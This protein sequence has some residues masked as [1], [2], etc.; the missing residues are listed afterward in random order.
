MNP[1]LLLAVV[2]CLLAANA[3]AQQP[4]SR[5]KSFKPSP[6]AQV[7]G[8]HREAAPQD[9][10]SNGQGGASFVGPNDNCAAATAISGNGPFAFDTVGA[11]TDGPA[12]CTGFS[13]DVWFNWTASVSATFRVEL[14]GGATF[15]TELAVYDG[16]AC[17]G[18]LIG[19]NDD[20]CGLQSRMTFNAING[21][22][23]KIQIGGY[24]G[25]NGT[26]SFTITQPPPPP[27]P[28]PDLCSA[29]G[30]ISGTGPFNFNNL[31][32]TTGTQGQNNPSCNLSGETGI[33]NDVWFRWTAAQN[34]SATLTLCGTT[35]GVDTKVAIYANVSGCPVALA[36]AC[37][38]DACALES[39]ITWCVT[40]GV[41]Y[42][43]QLG[44][45]PTASPGT[46]TF[47]I[48]TNPQ[49]SGNDECGGAL[50]LAPTGPYSFNTT[51]ATTS[52]AGQSNSACS[53]YNQMGIHNDL[54]FTWTAT[55]T[56]R[57]SLTTCNTAAGMDSRIAIYQGGAC[58]TG[59]AISCNDDCCGAS[60]LESTASW[61]AV[62]GQVYLIQ[63]GNYP[64]APAGSGTFDIT[65]EDHTCQQDD[66]TT[67]NILGWVDGGDL[68]WMQLFGAAGLGSTTVDSVEVA[69]GSALF[70]GV[71]PGN[72]TAAR[73]ALWDDPND[74]GDPSD[75]VLLQ[76]ANTTVANVDT[77]TLNVV[78]IP[79]TSVNGVYF[80]GASLSHAANQYV[81]P[82]DEDCV[83]SGI[84][85][86][87]GN[88]LPNATPA[89]LSNVN[90]NDQ[91]PAS[92]DTIGASANLLLRP[93][94]VVSPM[95]GFCYP[96][97][98]GVRSCPCGNQPVPNDGTRGCN[99]Y[100]PTPAGGT[101]GAILTASGDAVA[102]AS[103]TVV[104]HV[105]GMQTPCTI[106]VLFAGTTTLSPG[107]QSGGG[108]RCIAGLQ[109]PRPYKSAAG[110]NAGSIDFPSAQSNPN[111][112]AWTR[113]NSPAPGVTKHYYAAYRNPALGG[114]PP[115][116]ASNAFNLTNAGSVTWHP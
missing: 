106:V 77:D 32:A 57:A 104:F 28:S 46:G 87:F 95:E 43:I 27:P 53:F 20:F 78:S 35:D 116:S 79:T 88:I 12:N 90:N 2:A 58:P 110:F 63:I 42:M 15:D 19:C 22:V 73:V 8:A 4:S 108:V 70:P 111:V 115:C 68:V 18:T 83:R 56:G 113:S 91:G 60:G 49:G 34:G 40:N 98:D 100:G 51:A 3:T 31:S 50:A 84:A 23:Y 82:M 11:N 75:A 48:T 38:D 69:W 72:G 29:P 96:N 61:P 59:Q 5:S 7:K 86:R 103:N 52:C 105:N 44:N 102:S 39:T 65:V 114:H 101:G 109:V 30:I 33:T 81:A 6:P 99:N 97:A 89:D 21:Q 93:G 37:N 13:A 17:L 36:V 67:E 14:C 74:D 66:G 107:V 94:C 16:A 92:F 41:H 112:D 9:S 47:A 71:G 85:W 62:S 76:S 1:P 24:Q 55:A 25:A 54:W 26:G 80:I 10:K 45:Y 64:G